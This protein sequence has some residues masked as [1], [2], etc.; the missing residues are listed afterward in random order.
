[1]SLLY[2]FVSFVCNVFCRNIFAANG[3]YMQ[4][5]KRATTQKR[6]DEK[7]AQN[8]S[9]LTAKRLMVLTVGV[10]Y[11]VVLRNQFFQVSVTDIDV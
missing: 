6:K 2:L 4:E 8:R 3:R 9:D 10:V 5:S 1:M 7:S 11:V